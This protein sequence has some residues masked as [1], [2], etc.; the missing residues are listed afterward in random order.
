MA[1]NLS[2]VPEPDSPAGGDEPWEYER[3]EGPGEMAD[4]E[5]LG[6]AAQGALEGAD[7]PIQEALIPA[8]KVKFIGMAWDSLDEVPG[9]KDELTFIVRAQVVGHEQIVDQKT[10]DIRDLAK[11]KVS[12]VQL[13][14]G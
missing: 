2:V 1:P 6:T 8:C 4:D 7:E 13:H 5:N 14:Q 10:G 12:S 9:L 3:R 11:A